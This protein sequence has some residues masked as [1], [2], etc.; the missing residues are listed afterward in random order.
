MK[1]EQ[2]KIGQLY[3]AKVTDKVV[4]VRIEAEHASGGWH[5]VNTITNRKVHIKSAA[6]LRSTITIPKTEPEADEAKPA[7]KKLSINERQARV[8]KQVKAVEAEK[9]DAT[10]VKRLSLIDAAAQVL[11]DHKGPMGTKKMVEQVLQQQLWSPRSGGKTP[12]ATLYSAILREIKKKGA[13]A[14]FQKVERGQFQL[15][16]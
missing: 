11:G 3:S 4:P 6:K 16:N 13:D 2:I 8:Q 15:A 14:R 7:K 9:A 1:K 12:H 10:P 5:A